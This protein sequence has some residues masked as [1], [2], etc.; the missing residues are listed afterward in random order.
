M[1]DEAIVDYA[2]AVA[3]EIRQPSNG[4]DTFVRF[5]FKNG[6]NDDEFKTYNFFNGTSD[7]KLSTF[8]NTLSVRIFS[9]I[10]PSSAK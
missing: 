7:V 8:V 9:Y 4:G 1:T 2:A 5:Q 3:F 6:T 10:M